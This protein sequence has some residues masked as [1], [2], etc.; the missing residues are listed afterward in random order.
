MD[1][2]TKTTLG[3]SPKC[4]LTSSRRMYTA[5]LINA[6]EKF[7]KNLEWRVFF[8]LNP[9][10]RGEQ[11]QNYGFKTEDRP[12]HE[13]LLDDFKERFLTLLKT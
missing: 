12:K 7:M 5:R 4:V 10:A 11:K 1:N 9:G 13:P 2:L 3:Y 6:A 8:H